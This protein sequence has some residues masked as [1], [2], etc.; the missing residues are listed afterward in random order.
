MQTDY[1]LSHTIALTLGFKVAGI[2]L[3]FVSVVANKGNTAFLPSLH[4]LTIG[5]VCAITQ[6]AITDFHL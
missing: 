6:V 2:K 1:T 4:L 5:L 3:S